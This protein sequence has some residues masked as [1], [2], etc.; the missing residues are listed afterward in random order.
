MTCR[1]GW[2]DLLVTRRSPE[3]HRNKRPIFRRQIPRD[4]KWTT[5]EEAAKRARMAAQSLAGASEVTTLTTLTLAP[6][7]MDV[8]D[9]MDV[10]YHA[11][12]LC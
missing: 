5:C 12:L 11:L 10:M 8:M 1:S 2:T 3:S 4:L 6:D 7:D 9:V